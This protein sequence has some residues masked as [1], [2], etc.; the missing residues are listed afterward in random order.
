MTGA[1][2]L[3]NIGRRLL[4]QCACGAKLQG[5]ELGLGRCTACDKKLWLS[6]KPPA[7]QP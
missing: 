4:G 3:D 1:E 2:F 6:I 5:P 7:V